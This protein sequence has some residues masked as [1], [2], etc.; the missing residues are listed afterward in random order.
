M[1]ACVRRWQGQGKDSNV[2]GKVDRIAEIRVVLVIRKHNF[3]LSPENWGPIQLSQT[4][5]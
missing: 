5:D 3:F 4:I 2:E 1:F